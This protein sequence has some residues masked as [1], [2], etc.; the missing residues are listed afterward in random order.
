MGLKRYFHF[1]TKNDICSPKGD[2]YKHCKISYDQNELIFFWLIFV[3]YHKVTTN[4]VTNT[5][6]NERKKVKQT[7]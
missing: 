3:A 5:I 4:S 2:K 7:C 6:C 1:N